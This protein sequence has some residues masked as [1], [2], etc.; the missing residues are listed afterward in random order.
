MRIRTAQKRQSILDA[1][2]ALFITS[3]SF[4]AVSVD[5]IAAKANISKQT[6]YSYFDTKEALFVAM[7][8][9]ILD[10]P[11]NK[12]LGTHSLQEIHDTQS[13][14][15]VLLR[16]LETAHSKLMSPTYIAILRIIIVDAKT[17]EHLITDFRTQ[18][19]QRAL[20]AVTAIMHEGNRQ[21]II[22]V[23]PEIGARMLIGTLLT[24]A[25]LDGLLQSKNP[26]PLPSDALRQIVDTFMITTNKEG[27]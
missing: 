9:A 16:I 6:V 1:A 12:E 5:D 15:G 13:F 27:L 11:W 2:Q 8:T 24:Y 14:A 22:A 4:G 7:V 17:H 3:G 25:M 18:I 20:A 26:Q 21:G 10:E 19:V 23:N